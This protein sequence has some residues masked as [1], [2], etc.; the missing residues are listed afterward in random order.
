MHA[1]I[2]GTE[3]TQNRVR[4]GVEADIGVR[5]AFQPLIVRHLDAAEHHVI[6]G[7]KAMNIETVARADIRAV[8]RQ[9]GFGARRDRR[10]R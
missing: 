8:T 10:R 4:D 1:D 3:R 6:A 7:G 2:A 5:K 9:H